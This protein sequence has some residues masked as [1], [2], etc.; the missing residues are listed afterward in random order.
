LGGP[1]TTIKVRKP[2]REQEEI[3]W[4][5]IGDFYRNEIQR[6]REQLRKRAQE[7]AIEFAADIAVN[8][9]ADVLNIMPAIV[10]GKTV[11][12]AY[13]EYKRTKNVERAVKAGVKEATTTMVSDSAAT[14]IVEAIGLNP[15]DFTGIV[16]KNALSKTFEEIHKQV[17]S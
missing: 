8:I 17:R 6:K 4:R 7:R 3:V 10:I 11:I 5:R 16:I 14:I 13:E 1:A 15:K 12:A 2:S 9:A